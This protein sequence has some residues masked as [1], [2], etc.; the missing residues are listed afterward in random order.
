MLCSDVIVREP[1]P[2]EECVDRVALQM[3]DPSSD[4]YRPDRLR[5]LGTPRI[6]GDVAKLRV[7]NDADRFT[8]T[9]ERGPYGWRL[10]IGG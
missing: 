8:I 4:L 9:L 6:E 1:E 5:P 10:P 2:L 7:A 3:Q